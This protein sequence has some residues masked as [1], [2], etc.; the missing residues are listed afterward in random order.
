MAVKGK[1]KHFNVRISLEE[2]AKIEKLAQ[3][4]NLTASD[5]IRLILLQKDLDDVT[6]NEIKEFRKNNELPAT[7]VIYQVRISEEAREAISRRAMELGFGVRG[8]SKLARTMLQVCK[9][10]L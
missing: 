2:K 6:L 9:L 8:D 5:Y 7:D 1:E 3:Q 10:K 4:S